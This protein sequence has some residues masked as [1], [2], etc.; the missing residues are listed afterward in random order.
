MARIKI[1]G[2]FEA[3]EIDNARAQKVKDR[4]FGNNGVEK[5]EPQELV[6]LGNWAGEYGRI[7]EIE[8]DSTRREVSAESREEIHKREEKEAQ[9]TWERKTPEEKGESTGWFSF[10]YS[11]EAGDYSARPSEKILKK[12]RIL[13][14]AYFKK[15]P[16]VRI[17][18]REEYGD[19]LV[20]KKKLSTE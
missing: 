1:R 7:V 3:I 4:K 15:N 20:Q 16:A 9:E 19:L 10:A 8:L 14:T 2:R 13:Q 17:M 12:A 11:S 5:A 6:D 18:P